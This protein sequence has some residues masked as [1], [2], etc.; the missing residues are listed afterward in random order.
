LAFN[1]DASYADPVTNSSIWKFMECIQSGV[2]TFS[3]SLQSP[4]PKVK[5]AVLSVTC[6]AKTLRPLVQTYLSGGKT[7]PGK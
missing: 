2:E 4:D 5:E 3:V 1:L 6:E 7:R